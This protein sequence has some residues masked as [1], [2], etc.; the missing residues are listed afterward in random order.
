MEFIIAIVIGTLIWLKYAEAHPM[1]AKRLQVR[2]GKGIG[3]WL[4]KKTK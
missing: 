4:K 2:L 1:E 3:E